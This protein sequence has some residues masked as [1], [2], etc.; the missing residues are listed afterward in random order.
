ML[1]KHIFIAI[2][3]MNAMLYSNIEKETFQLQEKIEI[4]TEDIRKIRISFFC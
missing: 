1:N 4:D 2:L 3:C